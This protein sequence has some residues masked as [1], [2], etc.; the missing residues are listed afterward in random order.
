MMTCPDPNPQQGSCWFMLRRQGWAIGTHSFVRARYP[1]SL[2]LSFSVTSCQELLKRLDQASRGLCLATKYTG[3]PASSS[4]GHML[5]NA[6]Y[7]VPSAKMM[8][9]KPKSLNFI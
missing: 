2:C 4:P 7:S 8:A 3:Q 9:Q 6:E 1:T 5:N